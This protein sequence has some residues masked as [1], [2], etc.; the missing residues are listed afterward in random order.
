MAQGD[1]TTSLRPSLVRQE[2]ISRPWWW[3]ALALLVVVGALVTYKASGSLAT[4]ARV[5]ANHTLG[6][7]PE[8]VATEGL[9]GLARPL[10]R[11]VNY[12]NI[13]WPALFFG[14]LIAA[15]VRAL[16]PAAWLARALGGPLARA[17]LVGGAIGVPLMLCSCC[18]APVFTAV[19]QRSRRAGPASALMLASPALNPAALIL[20]FML[21]APAVA[22]TRAAMALLLVFGVSALAARLVRGAEPPALACG[23]E[24]PEESPSLRAVWHN[25]GAELAAVSRT[26]LPLIVAGVLLSSVV[27]DVVPVSRLAHTPVQVLVV[28]LVA[29]V[30]V[31][32]ALPTFAEI[33]LALGLLSGGAPIA[34]ATALLIAGPA[35]NLPSM[36]TL[37][38][39]VTPRYAIALG[40]GTLA[41][42]LIGALLVSLL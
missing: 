11:T 2:R 28:I 17:Q 15:T 30:G 40:V 25:F 20:T 8:L 12:L 4:I 3:G 32:I 24:A 35:I 33:P 14:V 18:V 1:W 41:V 34:A 38:K 21:F 13:V 22:F 19:H 39:T 36:L 23:A 7:K 9:P 31:L 42:S 26:T 27:I 16:V 6:P 37:G 10:A 5:E 29:L